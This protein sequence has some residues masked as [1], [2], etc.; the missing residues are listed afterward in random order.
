MNTFFEG[1]PEAV[2]RN[3]IWIYLIFVLSTLAVGAG[4][5]K[6][7]LD[8]SMESYFKE[9][10]PIKLAYD[11]FRA[12]FGSDEG[13]YIVYKAKDGDIFSDASLTAVQKI[14][15]ELLDYR[16]SLPFGE[17]SPL[18][19][20][21]DVKTIINVS[22]LEAD[23]HTLISREFIGSRFP[24]NAQ[25]RELLRRQALKH[26]D[27]PLAFLSEDSRFGGIIIRT[28]FS[29]TVKGSAST[30]PESLSDDLDDDEDIIYEEYDESF[31]AEA[32]D[33][34]P[35][36]VFQPTEMDEYV[37][38]MHEVYRI[39][40][41]PEYEKVL[42]FHP[43]G[44]AVLM[45]F[46]MDIF[47]NEMVIL[48]GG[49]LLL[50]ILVLWLLFRSLSAVLWPVVIISS[51]VIWVVGFLGWTGATMTPLINLIVFLVL[52]VGVADVVHIM[53]GY[54]YF[55]NQNL[56][57][58]DAL[59]S[60]FR[61][62]GLA[63]LLTSVTTAIGM[64]SLIFVPIVPIKN[65]GIFAALGVLFAF[66]FTVFVLPV[67]LDLWNPFSKARVKQIAEVGGE[68]HVLQ[69][70]LLKIQPLSYSY[71]VPVILIFGLCGIIMVYGLLKVK[72]DSDLME[73]IKDGL[74]IK[75]SYNLVDRVMMG[76]R[77]LEIMIDTG[78]EDGLKNPEFLNSIEKL[79]DYMEGKQVIVKTNSIVNVVKDSFRVLNGGRDDMYIIPQDERVLEQTLFMFSNVNP[80]DRRQLVSDDFSKAR[81]TVYAKGL[82]SAG[83]EILIDDI[84]ASIDRIFAHHKETYPDI[85]IMM[86][87][88]VPL[89]IKVM[90]YIS[91]SQIQ[92]F[93][94]AF[95]VISMILIVIFGSMKV[96]V[97]AMIPNAF[98]IITL[99]GIMGLF[100]ISLDVDT[101][102][103]AP[104]IIGIA[105]DDTIHFITHYR[106][107]VLKH[108]DVKNAII[109]TFQ[110][111]GQAIVF[112]SIILSSGFMIFVKSSHQGLS[113]VGILSSIAI[114]VALLADLLLLPSLLTVFNADFGLNH[115]EGT[116]E[117]L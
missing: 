36:P 77:N 24:E 51:S 54:L 5:P 100:N 33:K 47:T 49:S 81:I 78:M 45:E 108:G 16:M 113:H 48:S 88:S 64:I 10:D 97:I 52:T 39:I 17:V 95:I 83:F 8:M 69:K 26:P 62:S 73:I 35:P 46:F 84:Q 23:E 44:N 75:D 31:S 85:D 109:S 114:F 63:C 89:M 25:E 76:S 68:T 71:P 18:D 117:S 28:D 90:N 111:V 80:E 6:F 67:M 87:G 82:G 115:V 99:F 106:A 56:S 40:R 101:L 96:G 14:Q 61:K 1:T 79:Q 2:R 92:S 60:V 98:P 53:S 30:D 22:Y 20:M 50:I 19:H 12:Q 86:T 57:H 29:A 104:I 116:G 13:V 59:R 9:G 11:R 112:T 7:K 37:D 38:F 42:E 65:F 41:K 15:N 91:R 105:V 110:E 74:P 3:K 107:E 70:L 34:E 58:N 93:S 55:R 102:L 27:Y 66:V 21:K 94:M 32:M 4:V 103:T 72:V 43:V